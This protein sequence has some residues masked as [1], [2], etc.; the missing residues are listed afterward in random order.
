MAGSI[1][2]IA[3]AMTG[4]IVLPDPAF[5]QVVSDRALSDVKADSVV[6][7][8]TLTVTF[9]IRVQVL[10]SFP[11]SGRELHVRI[12][13]LDSAAV[14]QLRESLRTPLT[15]PELRSIEYE[16]DNPAGPTLSL[17]FTRDMQFAVNAGQQ[18]QQLV[19]TVAEPGGAMCSPDQSA[20]KSPAPSA[21]D[22]TTEGYFVLNLLS[23]PVS[24]PELSGAQQAALGNDIVY[25]TLFERGSQNWHRL[26][27]GFFTT[28]AEADAER[29]RLAKLFPDAWV[30]KVTPDEHE[31]GMQTRRAG[32]AAT[33]ALS[34][35]VA[36]PVATGSEADATGTAQ[37]I[38]D[39]EQAIQDGNLDRAVQ[40]LT[41]AAQ[42]PENPNSARAVELLGV[43]REKKGQSA[44][45]R[46]QYEEYLRRYPQGEG[47]D[48]V[49]QRL[50]ALDSTGAPVGG[51]LRQASSGSARKWT[52]GLRGSFSQ[53][54]FRDQ[55]RT[56][57]LT[58]SSTLGTE[59]D[60]SVNV[61]QLLT[62]GDI[63]I[64]GGNDRRQFQIRA[65]G[66]YT[67]N[68]GTSAS[69]TTI[70]NGT[71]VQTYRSRPGG[72]ISAVTALY[73]DYTDNDLN[74]Q[75][76]LGRQT[77]NSAGVLG[78]FDGALVGFQFNPHLRFN[79]V[80]GFPVLS[81]RQTHVLTE[82]PFYGVSIDVG[83]K[84]SPV[85]VTLYW[86]DQ[87]A[88]GGFIDRRSVGIETRFLRPRFNAYA[89]ADYDVK[90]G[91]LNL[92]LLSL[93]YNFPD[94][95]NLSVTADYRRSPLLTTTNALIGQFDTVN[96]VPFADLTG[97]RPFFTDP[98]IYQMALDRTLVAKSITATYSRPLTK[99]LQMSA[100]VSLTDTGGTPGTPATVGTPEV[101]ALPATGK[102]YYYGLQ[103]IGSDL[104]MSNDIYIL[105][106][107][108]ANTA[109]AKIYTFD[110]NARLPITS[111]FRLSPRLRYGW[112]DGKAT[113]LAPGGTFNQFQPTLRLNYFPVRH[114]EIEV[115]FGGNFTKQSI[116]NG[117]TF[118]H[119]SEAGW[120]LSAGY[121]LDF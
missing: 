30:T 62:T 32:T 16:G 111:K 108:F 75:L 66:S 27:A 92:G 94:T 84:R 8:T 70:N 115:E 34:V 50:A 113:T 102:E 63:T 120:V 55:G 107:R 59:V 100:D 45:A 99:K 103:L 78:R 72:G 74:T 17:F 76:R 5:G 3:V 52:W 58:T 82:R 15:V 112:R 7:C 117:T 109:T 51:T 77:R 121:R 54:Y 10:S 97:L 38:T 119:V 20:G 90:F 96:S 67:K 28:R 21:Q 49:R 98:Q 24:L 18:P 41:N 14:S 23:S 83:A 31:Q 71:E 12:R 95:S 35:A 22:A 19:V 1:T 73:F 48:R 80:A 65:A 33:G 93:N 61:N 88:K 56:S 26:R 101:F 110:F 91:V 40:L 29:L 104:V 89:I 4:G 105:S 69:I 46:A 79:A 36:A 114:S 68:F 44:Q 53:F 85:Q 42:K 81:S 118:D 57:T 11:T 106:G 64:S 9:N 87:H 43:V 13:P 2:A 86:F 47:A 39:A 25:E 6:G 60:N 37:L 116:Y